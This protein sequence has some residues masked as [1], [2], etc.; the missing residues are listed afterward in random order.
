MLTVGNKTSWVKVSPI[1]KRDREKKQTGLNYILWDLKLSVYNISK[2]I[3]L[4]KNCQFCCVKCS[5]QKLMKIVRLRFVQ[6]NWFLIFLE[7][8]IQR[9]SFLYLKEL[10]DYCSIP[11]SCFVLLIL[12]TLFTL[13]NQICLNYFTQRYCT[14]S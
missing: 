14:F 7:C 4:S 12:F 13:D 3:K 6:L 8:L 1:S 5:Q 11:D 9:K 10:P 2:L